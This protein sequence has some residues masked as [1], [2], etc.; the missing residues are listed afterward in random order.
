MKRD[1][2]FNVEFIFCSSTFVLLIVCVCNVSVNLEFIFVQPTAK[3][4]F[5]KTELVGAA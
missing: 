5:K 3:N 1:S 4:T 2:F